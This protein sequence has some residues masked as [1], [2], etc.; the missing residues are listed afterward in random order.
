MF[1]PAGLPNDSSAT[2]S[3]DRSHA[4]AQ[5]W[6]KPIARIGR[7]GNDEYVLDPI[8]DV[9]PSTGHMPASF[10]SRRIFRPHED[11]SDLPND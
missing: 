3:P 2:G 1:R 10:T 5:P 9:A 4:V 7:F 8:D 6:F 11:R